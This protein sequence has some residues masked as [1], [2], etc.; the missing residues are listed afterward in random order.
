MD[1]PFIIPLA[2]FAMVALIVAIVNMVKIRDQ[3]IDVR[4]RLYQEELEHRRKMSELD[5]EL[6]RI[7]QDL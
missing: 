3:E 7:K 4:Q 1:E 6:E 2:C 5:L